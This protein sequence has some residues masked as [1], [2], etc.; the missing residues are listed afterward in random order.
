MTDE[1]LNTQSRLLNGVGAFLRSGYW[2]SEYVFVLLAIHV[3]Y[4]YWFEPY[5][6]VLDAIDIRINHGLATFIAILQLAFVMIAI[7]IQ[8]YRNGPHPKC[9]SSQS[10]AN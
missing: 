4:A 1:P 3:I 6:L 9:T 5:M 10:L 7:F 2:V 8:R